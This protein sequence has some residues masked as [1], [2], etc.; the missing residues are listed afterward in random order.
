MF[1]ETGL[2]A[3]DFNDT[4]ATDGVNGR[5]VMVENQVAN[6][7]LMCLDRVRNF[8]G[9]DID[10]LD[11]AVGAADSHLLASLVEFAA[12]SDCVASV[13]VANLLHHPDVPDLDDTV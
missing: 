1:C 9:L 13:D 4:V 6:R 12:V 11:I 10:E 2:S 5:I 3:P 8:V 7:A